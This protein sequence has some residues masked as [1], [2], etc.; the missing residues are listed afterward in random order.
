M[1]SSPGATGQVILSLAP[2]DNRI[3]I[4][5]SMYMHNE[6]PPLSITMYCLLA[7]TIPSSFLSASSF[8]SYSSIDDASLPRDPWRRRS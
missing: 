5:Q 2:L 8:A 3:K 4:L 7:M 6:Q 1:R